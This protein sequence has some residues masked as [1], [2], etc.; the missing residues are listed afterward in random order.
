[1][2]LWASVSPPIGKPSLLVESCNGSYLRRALL[3]A[4]AIVFS[5]ALAAQAQAAIT[6]IRRSR[7]CR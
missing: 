7:R 1:M 4:L 6:F 3:I 2:K 5:Y